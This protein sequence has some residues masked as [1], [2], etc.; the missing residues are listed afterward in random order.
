[1]ALV[2][3]FDI[4]RGGRWELSREELPI[5]MFTVTYETFVGSI[6]Q[7]VFTH[8]LVVYA[9]TFCDEVFV[10]HVHMIVHRVKVTLVLFHVIHVYEVTFG[11]RYPINPLES[12]LFLFG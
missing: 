1:M 3:P 12:P 9:C 6:N 10:F 4:T 5:P 2:S 7:Y 8:I 11:T